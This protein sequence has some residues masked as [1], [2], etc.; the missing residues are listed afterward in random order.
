[1][2]VLRVKKLVFRLP[3]CSQPVT[4]AITT[5]EQLSKRDF[6]RRKAQKSKILV[7]ANSKRHSKLAELC[8]SRDSPQAINGVAA[9][10]RLCSRTV[11]L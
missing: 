6:A 4:K 8:H 5:I 1:M 10:K 7:D 2:D 11:K 9:A 3:W